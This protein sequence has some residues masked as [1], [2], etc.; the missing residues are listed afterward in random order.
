VSVEL[1]IAAGHQ[2]TL[3]EKGSADFVITACSA[4]TQRLLN[5]QL[6]FT[7]SPIINTC[8]N[9]KLSLPPPLSQR[10]SSLSCSVASPLT[11]EVD[12]VYFEGVKARLF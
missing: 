4:Y 5:R 7:C 12:P 11:R 1:Y 10:P 6:M 9:R 2:L 8:I 3:K